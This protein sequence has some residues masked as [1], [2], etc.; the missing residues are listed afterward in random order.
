[1]AQEF[2]SD[3]KMLKANILAAIAEAKAEHQ[4]KSLELV[5]IPAARLTDA[6]RLAALALISQR[7]VAL[8][9]P[10]TKQT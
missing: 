10:A 4:L 7:R 6:E 5:A 8:G 1:M 2:M 9:F 3:D